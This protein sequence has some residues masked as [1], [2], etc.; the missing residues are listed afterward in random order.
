MRRFRRRLHH[1]CRLRRWRRVT[2]WRGREWRW[3]RSEWTS[4]S[5]RS[6]RSWWT[7]APSATSCCSTCTPTCSA[8]RRWCTTRSTAP[9]SG[10]CVPTSRATARPSTPVDCRSTAVNCRR[11]FHCRIWGT[12]K[13]WSASK[14]SEN[15][16]VAG[17]GARTPSHHKS[18]LWDFHKSDEKFLT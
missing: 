18:H 10:F 7:F 1:L 12:G 13:Q 14:M 4:S 15:R 11:S 3:T 6:T 16:G 2:V 17:Q 5:C 9:G 8:A